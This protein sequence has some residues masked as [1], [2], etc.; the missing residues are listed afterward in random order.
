MVQSLC[1]A[2]CVSNIQFMS[3]VWADISSLSKVK[4]NTFLL[5]SC[6]RMNEVLK[7]HITIYCITPH[8]FYIYQLNISIQAGLLWLARKCVIW[9]LLKAVQWAI[10]SKFYKWKLSHLQL[11]YMN[12][13]LYQTL[14]LIVCFYINITRL[15]F[16]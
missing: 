14:L 2:A 16:I 8:L 6:N 5:I 3:V 11:Y 15:L 4:R 1:D 7:I 10:V 12:L 9:S 13:F